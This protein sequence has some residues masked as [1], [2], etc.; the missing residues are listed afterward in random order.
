MKFNI[1]PQTMLRMGVF[2]GSYWAAAAEEDFGGLSTCV[3]ALARSCT[4][5]FDKK[6]NAY[7]VKA[8]LPFGLWVDNGWIF[9]EDPLGWFQWYCRYSNGRRHFRDEHQLN[10]HK[11][12][13]ERWGLRARQQVAE[14]GYCSPVIKQGLLQW[15][16]DPRILVDKEIISL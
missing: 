1:D 4:V 9:P 16:H 11:R 3:E 12:Y 6:E 2:G 5:K 8:G 10:R 14:R 7:G 15:A 13:G